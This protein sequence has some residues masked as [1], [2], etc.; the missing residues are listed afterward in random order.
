[1]SVRKI[2]VFALIALAEIFGAVP[3][4]VALPPGVQ[5]LP[6]EGMSGEIKRRALVIGNANYRNFP[7]LLNAGADATAVARATQRLGFDTLLA[8]DLDRRSMNE[9]VAHFLKQIEPGSEVLFYYAGHGVEM[10]G[11]NY[12]LPTDVPALNPDQERLLRSEGFNLTELMQDM[13]SRKAR[14]SVMIL[15]ACRDNPFPRAATRSVGSKR[16]LALVEPPRGSFVIF[17]AGVGEMALDGLGPDDPDPNGLFTRHLLRLIEQEGLEIHTLVRQLR[18]HVSDAAQG[19][20]GHQQLPSYYD[21]MRGEFFF[22]RTSA[23]MSP[24]PD[25]KAQAAARAEAEAQA[26][27]AAAESARRK[28]E[29]EAEAKRVA[30]EEAKRKAEAK[31]VADMEM[32]ARRVA[33]EEA[34]AAA[35]WVPALTAAPLSTLEAQLI[36]ELEAKRDGLRMTRDKLLQLY[37]TVPAE[38]RVPT[39][40]GPRVETQ[41]SSPA[42]PSASPAK[43]IVKPLPAASPAVPTACASQECRLRMRALTL[44]IDQLKASL[45]DI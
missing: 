8:G 42:V 24:A 44:E 14:V 15:D 37:G 40:A 41:R 13:E 34:R 21:Q 9:A 2:L 12:L 3:V 28:A 20:S 19:Y 26:Q 36:A 18:D 39:L 38:V 16:G 4:A 32:E 43:P 6:A 11:A 17:S 7:K 31:R 10:Q 5:L 35:A 45:P 33:A 22:R 1:M 25:L 23:A 29:V 27:R 30:A